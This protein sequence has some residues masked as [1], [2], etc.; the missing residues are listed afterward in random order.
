MTI[1]ANHAHLMPTPVA[2]SWW[3]AGDSDMLLA[4]LDAC[5]IDRVVVFPPFANQMDGSMMTANRWALR[6]V[7][8]HADRF[9]P[10]GTLNPLAADVLDVMQMCYDAGVRWI[11]IHPSIDVHDIADP[12]LEDFYGRAEGLGMILD[13]HTGPHGHAHLPRQR[14]EIRRSG[15]ESPRTAARL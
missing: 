11:K 13:Y 7:K 4:H 12:R 14:A 15:L 1:I 3:P 2:G 8:A 6:E 5:G 9:L 10:A